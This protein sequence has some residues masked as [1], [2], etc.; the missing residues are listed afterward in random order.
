MRGPMPEHRLA[1]VCPAEAT[2]QRKMLYDAEQLLRLGVVGL[3]TDTDE[4]FA[5]DN[6]RHGCGYRDAFGRRGVSWSILSKRRFAKQLAALMRAKGDERHYWLTHAHTRLVPPVHGFADFWYPGEELTG[7]LRS[8]IWLYQD[9]VDDDAWR[10]EYRSASSGIVHIFL[11][12][13]WRGSGDP[14]HLETR[15]PTESLL[16]MAAVND[17]NV[18]SP[19]ANAEAVGE[20]WGYRE[21]LGLIDASFTGHWEPDCPVRALPADARASLYRTRKGAV[22]VVATRSTSA[23]PVEV[24]LDLAALGLGAGAQ[25]RDARSGAKLALQGDRLSVPLAARSYTYVTL[26]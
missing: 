20:Y 3:Y 22:L 17:V 1:A 10:V 15:Q 25:A 12:E 14:K 26:R 8:N 4:V 16:A 19:Y 6:A 18:S 11:P 7:P 24:R 9:V 13:F 2:F 5:D 21:S 23:G